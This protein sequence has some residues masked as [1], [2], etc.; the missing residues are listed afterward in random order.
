MFVGESIITNDLSDS[1]APFHTEILIS[2]VFGE[3]VCTCD[4]LGAGV[5]EAEGEGVGI[6]VGAGETADTAFS[7]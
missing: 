7:G 3:G 4:A 1:D 2:V 5:G 6:E